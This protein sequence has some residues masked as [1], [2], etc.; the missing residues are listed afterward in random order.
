MVNKKAWVRVVEAF[1]AIMLIAGVIIFI[2][3]HYRSVP[4]ISVNIYSFEEG[5]LNEVKLN[6][7]LRSEVF[8]N[9]DLSVLP[10]LEFYLNKKTLEKGYLNCTFVICNSQVS[11][12]LN[13]NVEKELFAKSIVLSAEGE[14]TS[15]RTLYLFCWVK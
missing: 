1:F 6:S 12:K 7:T 9:N 3:N 5:V 2:A 4:D 10:A 8:R 11:C 14:N 15:P 13:Q